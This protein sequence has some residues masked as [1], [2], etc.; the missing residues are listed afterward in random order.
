VTVGLELRLVAREHWLGQ[1]HQLEDLRHRPLRLDLAPGE[2][3]GHVHFAEPEAVGRIGLHA[4]H[5][6]G[7][8]LGLA[9]VDLAGLVV[10]EA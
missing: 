8:H 3:H 7:L 10:L 4:H 9:E 2:G 6:V 5:H 1:R